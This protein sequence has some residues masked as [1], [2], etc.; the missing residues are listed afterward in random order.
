MDTLGQGPFGGSNL[1]A[2]ETF[3]TIWTD[4]HIGGALIMKELKVPWFH[5][6]SQSQGADQLILSLG[7]DAPICKNPLFT[8]V[9]P[10]DQLVSLLFSNS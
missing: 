5:W 10:F 4:G 3:S 8:Q 2:P 1:F 6:V 9:L 7:K